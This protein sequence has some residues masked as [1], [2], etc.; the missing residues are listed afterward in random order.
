M[1]AAIPGE[2][3]TLVRPQVIKNNLNKSKKT[4]NKSTNNLM[5]HKTNGMN[6]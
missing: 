6:A 2:Y 5:C 4:K 1:S 3:N